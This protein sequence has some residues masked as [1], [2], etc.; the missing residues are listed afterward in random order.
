MAVPYLM[1]ATVLQRTGHDFMVVAGPLR[2]TTS[3]GPYVVIYWVIKRDFAR[4]PAAQLPL[5]P[6]LADDTKDHADGGW[7]SGLIASLRRDI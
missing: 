3:Y 6:V 7:V 2:V 1:L 5:L 4:S